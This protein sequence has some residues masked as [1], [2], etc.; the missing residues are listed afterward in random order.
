VQRVVVID[1]ATFVRS[2]NHDSLDVV[3]RA[4][5]SCDSPHLDSRRLTDRASAAR[6]RAARAPPKPGPRMPDTTA[7]R[8]AE[9]GSRQLR[10]L[11]GQ[12]SGLVDC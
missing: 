8:K 4:I 11:V 9:P 10:A 12:R 7:S 2:V 5:G 1:E 6:A 3:L